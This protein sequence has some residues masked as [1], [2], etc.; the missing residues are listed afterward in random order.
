MEG[1]IRLLQIGESG[2]Q[3]KKLIDAFVK[4]LL[5]VWKQIPREERGGFLKSLAE[6]NLGAFLSDMSREERAS[7]M[8]TL[9][10][11]IAQKFPLADLDIL[12]VFSSPKDL[13]G[14]SRDKPEENE[15]S[16]K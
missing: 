8:N 1:I 3:P 14:A 10:P 6:E 9:L 13:Y 7:L 2:M 12:T 4:A 11:L 15:T 5:Q 16:D